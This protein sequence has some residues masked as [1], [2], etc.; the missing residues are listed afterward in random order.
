MLESGLECATTLWAFLFLTTDRGLSRVAAGT[1][2]SAY[3]AALCAGRLV[4]GPVAERYGTHRVLRAAAA[5]IILGAVLV[6]LPAPGGLAV[7]GIVVIALGAAPMFPLL[8]LTTRERV[9]EA[10]ADQTVGVQVAAAAVGAAAAPPLV[11]L[12]IGRYGAGVLGPCL[13]ALAV[14]TTAAY[15]YAAAM[16]R[17]T[18][19]ADG[20]R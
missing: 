8:T 18:Y 6:A 2:V 5:A 20:G 14:A 17:P 9:G 19:S 3:W 1:T 7:A 4:L 13:L 10:H 12:L 11:G 16:R 15:A